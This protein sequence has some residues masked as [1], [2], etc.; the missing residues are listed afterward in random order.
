[1]VED[2]QR[3][4]GVK[5]IQQCLALAHVRV[6]QHRRNVSLAR[7]VGEMAPIQKIMQP[8]ALFSS[9]YLPGL[10]IHVRVS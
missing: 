5:L 9:D 1:M 2:L 4:M 6:F 3:D 7:L 8:D 10:Y